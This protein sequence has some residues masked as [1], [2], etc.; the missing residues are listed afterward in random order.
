[1]QKSSP[2]SGKQPLS[3]NAIQ[4]LLVRCALGLSALLPLSAARALGRMMA[5]LYWP[6]G[7]RSRK[8]TQINIAAAFPE[9]PATEQRNLARQSLCST[10]ELFMEMGHVWLKPWAY[11]SGLIVR[12]TGVELI[13]EAQQSGRGVILLVPHLGNWEVIGLHAGTLG[14]AVSLYQPPKITGL[15]PIVKKA[16]QASGATLVPTD[17]RGLAKLLKSVKNGGISGILPDQAPGDI[18]S[19]Q[20]SPFMGIS[21]F[22]GTLASNMIRRTGALAVFGFAE[23]VPGGF[24]VHYESAEDAIY[25]EDTATS[26]AALNRGVERCVRS[27]VE[28]YQWEYK[29]FRKRPRDGRGLYDNM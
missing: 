8:V 18:N 21:C 11:V 6:I 27:C 25:D 26:L 7:G 4:L 9:L 5:A 24:A 19:G 10:A 15:G 3:M 2:E 14:S 22:T 29:R 16:R 12:K 20:N 1:L 17:G 28:Q 13:R 23:R